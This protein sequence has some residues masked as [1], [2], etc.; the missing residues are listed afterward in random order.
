MN[1]PKHTPGPWYVHLER[2][3]AGTTPHVTTSKKIGLWDHPVCT[4]NG[5][6]YQSEAETKANAR[7]IAAAP[8][9]LAACK[10]MSEWLKQ[11]RLPEIQGIA[12]D[13][14]QAIDKAEG[15]ANE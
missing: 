5:T 9:L 3:A 13:I 8:D 10:R 1:K 12:C 11:H 6:K 2:H 14:F 7:L 15:N 4:F